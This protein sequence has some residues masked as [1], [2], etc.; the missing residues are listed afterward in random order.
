[1]RL[2][3]S[4]CRGV[5]ETMNHRR[6]NPAEGGGSPDPEYTH[7]LHQAATDTSPPEDISGSSVPLYLVPQAVAAEIRRHG[8]AVREIHI[9]RTRNHQYTIDVERRR[10]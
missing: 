3:E 1:M 8:W 10:V 9:R 7:T 2:A 4:R 6:R 5:I